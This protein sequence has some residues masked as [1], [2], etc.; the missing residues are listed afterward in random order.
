MGP[1][2]GVRRDRSDVPS[3]R[4]DEASAASR[5]RPVRPRDAGQPPGDGSRARRAVPVR[6]G[7]GDA[8]GC[9]CPTGRATA[10]RCVAGHDRPG[11]A[12]RRRPA[13]GR[14]RPGA[15]VGV[16]RRHRGH[17]GRHLGR[18]RR[19]RGSPTTTSGCS[20]CGPRR[21]RPSSSRPGRRCG[22]GLWTAACFAVALSTDAR[23]RAWSCCACFVMSAG[24]LAAV[25]V[26]VGY[27]AGAM[28]RSRRLL[29]HAAWHDSLSGLP[30]REL[31]DRRTTE[32]L[33]A[34]DAGGGAVH[35]LLV[36]LDHFKLVNDTYGHHAGRPADLRGG[37]PPA[38]RAGGRGDRGPDGR[39]RVRRRRGRPAGPRWTSAGCWTACPRSGRSPCP[40]P[41]ARC[42]SPPASA[43]P[44]ATAP[45]RH[46]RAAA[47]GRGRR[48]VPGQEHPPRVGPPL[49]LRPAGRGGAPHP[50]R[51]RAAQRRGAAG[52]VAGLPARRRPAS[53]GGP[54]GRRRCCA[55]TAACSA[56]CR[57]RSS[58]RSPRTTGSSSRWA[59]SCSRRPP[60]TW[61][62]GAPRGPSTTT[63]PWPS[64]CPSASWAAGSPPSSTGCSWSTGCR[65]RP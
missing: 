55:G 7:A 47:A 35:V 63:S 6:G 22:H 23:A 58:C 9:C 39:R 53:A 4:C 10:T 20:T 42:P 46:G 64:T 41:A 15:A 65:R 51:P 57:R 54:S 37:R 34:R 1:G 40:W 3:R 14:H 48:P 33:A 17:P 50:A 11:G 8:R 36:D 16:P 45:G 49:R 26:L 43:S 18:L 52:A 44:R 27:V 61:R 59:A 12:A 32:A 13:R 24:T 21:S 5:C 38:G 31:F 29:Q 56:P 19:A 25:G 28:R 62:A 60:P 2:A 30:N